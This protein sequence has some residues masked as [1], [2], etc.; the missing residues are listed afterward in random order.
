MMEEIEMIKKCPLCKDTS[1]MYVH[2]NT[3]WVNG[4]SCILEAD[5]CYCTHS[6]CQYTHGAGP[7]DEESRNWNDFEKTWKNQ[8]GQLVQ[9]TKK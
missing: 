2:Y 9:G 7:W 6:T 4:L 3:D 5:G 1:I 8:Y